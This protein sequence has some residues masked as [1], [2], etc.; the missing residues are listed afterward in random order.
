MTERVERALGKEIEK[1]AGGGSREEPK[2]RSAREAARSP[3][4][5]RSRGR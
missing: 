2:R 1:M 4:A 3:R 5:G